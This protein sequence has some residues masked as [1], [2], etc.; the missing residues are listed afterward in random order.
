MYGTNV[1]TPT[2]AENMTL[3]TVSKSAMEQML[4]ICYRY[5]CKW[6]YFYNATKCAVLV[7]NVQDSLH[8]DAAFHIGREPIQLTS[9]QVHLGIH[10]DRYLSSKQQ[11][12]DASVKL[13]GTLISIVN[14][15]LQAKQLNPLLL[16][17]L[18][19]PAARPM[20]LRMRITYVLCRCRC[21]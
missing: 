16:M 5:P 20:A 6:R 7:F 3:I 17:T 14:N 4:D 19:T 18:Y 9:A 10:S 13:R 12:Y 8:N 1:S 15:G 21:T 2:F 11:L